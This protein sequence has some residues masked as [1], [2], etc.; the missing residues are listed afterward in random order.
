MPRL[1]ALT[2]LIL[3]AP[4]I[5]AETSKSARDIIDAMEQ[6]YRGEASDAQITMIVETPQYQRTL[7]M[8]GQSLGKELGF[9]RILAPK[10]DRGIATL[11]RDDEMWN[12][13]PKINKVIKVPPS[14]MMGSWMGSDFTND[15]LVKETQL[16]DDYELTMKETP[17]EYQVTLVPKEQ[18]VSL[19]GKIDYNVSKSPMLPVSQVFYDDAGEKVRLMTFTQPKEIGG[20]LMPSVL[21]MKPLNKEGHRTLVI[22]DAIAFDPPNISRDTFTMRQL[23]ARF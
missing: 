22:Y 12:Y 7:K 21:E 19:W 20:R 14:M 18:T 6:L 1:P 13:F 10:K 17:T 4:A 3:T 16:I 9:Y 11:K 8:S 2:L 5:A 23:K 15:D